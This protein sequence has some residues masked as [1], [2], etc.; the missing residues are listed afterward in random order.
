MY[1]ACTVRKHTHTQIHPETVKESTN[2]VPKHFSEALPWLLVHLLELRFVL[3]RPH[4]G[5]AVALFEERV[6][7][8]PYFVVAYS[9]IRGPVCMVCAFEEAGGGGARG[10]DGIGT[11]SMM[12]P[13]NETS[14]RHHHHHHH[15]RRRHHRIAPPL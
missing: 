4:E 1:S 5:D 2:L 14:T 12:A 3:K 6:D 11:V 13:V 7:A 8:L 10:L 9:L 15:H